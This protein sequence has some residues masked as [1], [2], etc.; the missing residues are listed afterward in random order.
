MKVVKIMAG[1][2]EK[3]SDTKSKNPNQLMSQTRPTNKSTTT[4]VNNVSE[5]KT[6]HSASLCDTN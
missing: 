3:H 5:N 4:T 6:M 2:S 1:D